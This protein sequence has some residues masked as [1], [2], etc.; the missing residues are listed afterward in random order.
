MNHGNVGQEFI[1]PSAFVIRAS[2]FTAAEP[3]DLHDLGFFTLEVFVNLFYGFIGELLD[4][5]FQ[6][7]KAVFG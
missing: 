4:A 7:M 6:V 3:L 1:I 5:G 2:S